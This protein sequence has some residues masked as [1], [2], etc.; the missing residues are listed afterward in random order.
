[1][2]SSYNIPTSK[3]KHIQTNQTQKKLEDSSMIERY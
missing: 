3:T 2:L 1:M